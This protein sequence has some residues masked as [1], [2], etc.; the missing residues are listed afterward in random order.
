LGEFSPN[1]CL[2]TLGSFLN[3][4]SSSNIL[5]TFFHRKSKLYLLMLTENVLG[6]I[7]GDVF[8]NTSG[9]PVCWETNPVKKG[10][11][12]NRCSLFHKFLTEN[13]VAAQFGAELLNLMQEK[14][15][16]FVFVP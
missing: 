16:R 14:K 9:H 4:R 15:T 11:K 8:A 13:K 6:F 10:V 7:L 12:Q 5:A 3:Y 1:G 2:L